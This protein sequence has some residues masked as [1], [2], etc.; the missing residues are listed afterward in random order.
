[1]RGPMKLDNFLYTVYAQVEGPW[2][3]VIL[4]H[5]NMRH[6]FLACQLNSQLHRTAGHIGTIIVSSPEI[7]ELQEQ[8]LGREAEELREFFVGVFRC[9]CGSIEA[10]TARTTELVK[11]YCNEAK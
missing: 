6:S 4:T 9:H 10:A 2:Y 1:M 3:R 11:V 5:D 7:A 8:G